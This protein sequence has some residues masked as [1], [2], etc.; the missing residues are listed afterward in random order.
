MIYPEWPAPASVRAVSTTRIGGFSQAPYD[1][2]NLAGHVGD[3]ADAVQANRQQLVKKLGLA[4]EPVWLEQVHG[5]GVVNAALAAGT[6]SADASYTRQSG[7][8]CAVMTVDCL[9]VLFCDQRAEVV[10][11]AH[12][13]WRGLASGV[14]EASVAAMG[15]QADSLL[16]W[17]GPAIGPAAFEVGDEVRTAFVDRQPEAAAA[18]S[19]L[20]SG[21]WLADI[22]QLARLRLASAGIEH[23]YGGD[24]CTFSDSQRFYSFRRQSTTGRM[25]SL[26]WI[27]S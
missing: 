20:G 14:L 3:K 13:G 19:R 21:Q 17:L 4:V 15:V 27:A 10:A 23:I 5:D 25:A 6:P 8:V 9:P 26:V 1:S 11:A 24:F 7:V 22:Y 16:A 12:A 18:F 2:L